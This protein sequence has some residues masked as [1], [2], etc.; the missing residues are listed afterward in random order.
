MSKLATVRTN[1]AALRR[2]RWRA[3]CWTGVGGFITAAVG[4]LA[5]VFALDYAFQPGVPVRV[6][7]L[8]AGLGGLC[9]AWRALA[10]PWLGRR[11]TELEMALLVQ[12]H[13]RAM[14]A[15]GGQE[16]GHRGGVA[17]DFAAALQF[18]GPGAAS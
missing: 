15:A 17:R 18:E 11:E 14:A 6:G 16:A 12:R 9:L 1:L 3:R 5:V 13:E 8:I 10:R 2:W 7:I 4:I